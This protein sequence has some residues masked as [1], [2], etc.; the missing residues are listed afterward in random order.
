MGLFDLFGKKSGTSPLKKYAD[1]VASKRVQV[2][3]RWEAI[4][5]L[6]RDGS[7]E[8]IEALLMRFTFYIEPSITDQEEKDA[9]FAGIIRAGEAA[10]GP[11]TA[12]LGSAESIS[13]PVKMLDELISSE[14]V[15]SKLLAQLDQMDVEYERDPQRK[16]QILATLEE[17]TDS[18]IVNAAGRFLEDANETVRFNA[19]GAVFAQ[20]EAG[21]CRESLITCLC[22]EESV[23]VRNRIVQGFIE[24]EWDFGD[25]EEEA[26]KHLPPGYALDA[27]GAPRGP[28]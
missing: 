8:A 4:Q 24:H 5:V 14:E 12:F 21:G 10:V 28:K 22:E 11:V 26:R 3:D 7:P 16:I 27:N 1:R 13:W 2:V 25:R 18:R 9:A 19:V 23:R 6:S 20:E 15:V 17:R